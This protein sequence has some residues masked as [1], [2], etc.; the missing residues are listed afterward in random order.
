MIDTKLATK[1][2]STQEKLKK[3]FIKDEFRHLLSS[4]E[5]LMP[6]CSAERTSRKLAKNK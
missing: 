3:L 2:K 6:K 1:Y 4:Y 5:M